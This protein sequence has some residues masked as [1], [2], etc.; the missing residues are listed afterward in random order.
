MKYFIA[1]LLF[2]SVI[3]YS[4]FISIFNS[5]INP[6]SPFNPVSYLPTNSKNHD[7]GGKIWVQGRSLADCMGKDKRIDNNVVQCHNGYFR[8]E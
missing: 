6:K 1:L 4:A 2:V 3:E 7:G 5:F 8:G